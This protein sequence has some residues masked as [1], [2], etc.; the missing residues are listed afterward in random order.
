MKVEPKLTELIT[1]LAETFRVKLTTVSLYGYTLALR[2]VPIACVTRAV[3]QSLK[4]CKFMPSPAD[5]RELAGDARSEDRALLAWNTIQRV[6]FN[7]YAWMDFEDTLINATIRSLG[8]W[9]NFCQRF[10]DAESEKWVRKEF[11]D[12][13]VRLSRTGGGDNCDVLPGLSRAGITRSGKQWYPRIVHVPQSKHEKITHSRATSRVI[14]SVET[15]RVELR[16]S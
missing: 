5:L 14:D 11:L 9:P 6:Q 12:A 1:L 15:P 3:E 4:T 13:Y 16:K 10:I 7:A 2:D 8:G